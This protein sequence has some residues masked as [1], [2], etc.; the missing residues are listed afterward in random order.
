MDALLDMR[1]GPDGNPFV[2]VFWIAVSLLGSLALAWI[3]A[4]LE[5]YPGKKS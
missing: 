4:K 3:V 2:M 1:I 5:G